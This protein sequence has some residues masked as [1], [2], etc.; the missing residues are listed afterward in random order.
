MFREKHN[1]TPKKVKIIKNNT[2]YSARCSIHIFSRNLMS[3]IEKIKKFSVVAGPLLRLIDNVSAPAVS[4]RRSPL[5]FIGTVEEDF[6]RVRIRVFPFTFSQNI[7]ENSRRS[8]QRPNRRF[9]NRL[10]NISKY[11]R[12]C[13]SYRETKYRGQ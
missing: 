7:A 4:G 2:F 13:N 5:Q 10:Q 1:L 12:P 8:D 11:F 3:Y 9:R 6:L